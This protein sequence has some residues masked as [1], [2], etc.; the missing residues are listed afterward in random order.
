MLV[1]R[2]L[3]L[4]S[5]VFVRGQ[6]QSASGPNYYAGDTTLELVSLQAFPDAVC[7]DGS[8]G[9]YYWS[10]GTNPDLW[11]L[12]LEGGFWCL[13]EDSC[14]GRQEMEPAQ[15]SSNSWSA[16][17]VAGGIFSRDTSQNPFAAANFAY[18]RYCSSDSWVGNAQAFG[19]QFRGQA[20]LQ[21]I[22]DDL[23][24]NKGLSAGANLL[25]SGCS[26]GGRGVIAQLDNVAARLE[27]RGVGV[28]GAV[29]SS[30]W[31]AITPRGDDALGGSL[32][33]QTQEVY[34]WANVTG[35][36]SPHC[37]AAYPDAPWNCMFGQFAVPLLRTSYFLS[38]SQLDDFQVDYDCS[39]TTVTTDGG[40]VMTTVTSDEVA[41]ADNVQT[42]IRGVLSGLPAAGQS[43]VGIFSSACSLHC[44]SNGPDWWTIQVGGQSMASLMGSWWFAFDTPKVVD[45]CTGA[46]CA[47]SCIP[48]EQAFPSGDFDTPV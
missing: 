9:G 39:S 46:A 30:L 13:S 26:A 21:A 38:Q 45:S 25:F 40:K 41:C 4:S 14:L 8:P 29:D 24:A 22:I 31:V 11:L 3:L 10:K 12:Y 43:A 37:L 17:T 33:E 7:N 28:R 16:T 47:Q 36:L 35:A 42:T 19:M 1:R 18:S 48:E 6:Q 27:A 23:F 32:L 44:V 34:S 2:A 20:I 15:V 5:L